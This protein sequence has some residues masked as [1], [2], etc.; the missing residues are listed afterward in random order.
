MTKSSVGRNSFILVPNS[1]VPLCCGKSEQE[2]KTETRRQ[3]LKQE[4]WRILLNG[5]SPWLVQLAS[6]Q[7]PGASAQGGSVHIGLGPPA[8]TINQGHVLWTSSSDLDGDIFS[9]RFPLPGCL[10]ITAA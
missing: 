2:L 7:D 8:S 6:L 9:I 4:F 3:E 10:G 1:Q 5:L